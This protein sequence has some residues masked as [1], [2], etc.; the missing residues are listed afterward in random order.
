M[1]AKY[2]FQE[3]GSRATKAAD[4]AAA[5]VESLTRAKSLWEAEPV[6]TQGMNATGRLCAGRPS[7]VLFPPSSRAGLVC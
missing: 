4:A 6:L 3:I 7:S 5:I 2:A 1:Q